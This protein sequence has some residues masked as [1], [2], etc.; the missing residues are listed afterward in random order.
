MAALKF[1]LNDENKN[2]EQNNGS[3]VWVTG[4]AS[5]PSIV[6]CQPT[7]RVSR[8]EGGGGHGKVHST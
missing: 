4:I 5:L 7:N 3:L 6:K 8:L 2:K 1:N